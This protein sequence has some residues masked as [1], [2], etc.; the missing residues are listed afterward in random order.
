MKE[1]QE[2]FTVNDGV[3]SV[4]VEGA[5]IELGRLTFSGRIEGELKRGLSGFVEPSVSWDVSAKGFEQSQDLR[6]A[7]EMGLSTTSDS[8][9]QASGSV[10]FDGLGDGDRS[11]QAIRLNLSRQ[12]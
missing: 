6:G 5:A 7:L 4:D 10:R 11:G 1:T 2:D 9:W 12:F 8:D 3:S